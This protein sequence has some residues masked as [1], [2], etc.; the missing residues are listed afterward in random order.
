MK[1]IP[2]LRATAACLL[3]AAGHFGQPTAQ[4]SIIGPYTADP[5]AQHLWPTD[6]SAVPVPDA[7]ASGGTNL[8]KL[9]NG[10]IL[11]GYMDYFGC[12]S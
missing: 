9:S 11:M 2:F 10:A 7:V 8:V 12:M 5:N 6:A 3:A 1:A 4:A